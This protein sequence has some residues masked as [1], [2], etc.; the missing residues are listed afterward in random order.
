[1]VIRKASLNTDQ[2]ARSL[3]QKAVR[4]GNA[5]IAKATFRY[6]VSERDEFDWVRSRLAVITFEEA[7]P[8]G[9][10]VTFGRSET[11]ILGHY[12]ALCTCAK[13]KDAAGLGSLAYALSE[14]DESVLAGDPD[15]RQIRVIAKAIKE[16]D[17]FMEWITGQIPP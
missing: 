10:S 2:V 9:M 12:T 3:L 6:L 14:G 8:Y 13:N 15:D 1:M 5:T 4:R 11:E 16:R 7:W 17:K